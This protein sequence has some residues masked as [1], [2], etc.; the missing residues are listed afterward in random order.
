MFRSGR[1]ATLV[2]IPCAQALPNG[3][4][5]SQ[6]A[7][8][9]VTAVTQNSADRL[10]AAAAQTSPP[11]SWQ[12]TS[13]P[14]ASSQGRQCTW[15]LCGQHVESNL[16]QVVHVRSTGWLDR[17]SAPRTSTLQ[18]HTSLV[19][20]IIG[21][22]RERSVR[23]APRAATS[24]LNSYALM[25]LSTGSLQG[26]SAA[27][28][29][30]RRQ[31]RA[32]GGGCAPDLRGKG[33]ILREEPAGAQV[34]VAGEQAAALHAALDPEH[35]VGLL[36]A[37]AGRGAQLEEAGVVCAPCGQALPWE[38]AAAACCCR[39]PGRPARTCRAGD[40]QE[41]QEV[42]R[43]RP[44]ADRAAVVGREA[45]HAP[46]AGP[47][48]GRGCCQLPGHE[49]SRQGRCCGAHQQ[50]HQQQ[51]C[52]RPRRGCWLLAGSGLWA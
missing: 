9:W 37:P 46:G 31:G 13:S 19:L 21:S 24:M 45:L 28:S 38:G 2:S 4:E 30:R 7:L 43:V 44:G 34:V 40:V 50:G 8:R 14:A 12:R 25:A 18:G 3:L 48:C 5:P 10:A 20:V 39:R 26:P 15:L 49:H 47:G 42:L 35:V 16:H 51:L 27:Q 23:K 41:V 6:A 11:D 32:P 22:A 36:A 52:V 29:C 1:V 17:T 33:C